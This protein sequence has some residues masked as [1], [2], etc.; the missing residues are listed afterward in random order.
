[1]TD[2]DQEIV[3]SDCSNPFTFTAQE[4]AFYTEKQFSPP[5]RCKPCREIRKQEKGGGSSRPPRAQSRD[6]RELFDATCGKCGAQTQVPFKPNPDR[7]V[8]CRGCFK[9]R[10]R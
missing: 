8:Y 2:Q 9:P 7:P 4:A 10:S 1:M 5:K 6:D 3:C